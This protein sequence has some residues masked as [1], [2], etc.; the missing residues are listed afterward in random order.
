MMVRS[1]LLL[2]AACATVALAAPGARAVTDAVVERLDP[3]TLI[4]RWRDADPVDVYLAA[5]PTQTVKDARLVV[6]A[7]RDGEERLTV[8]ADS[9]PYVLLRDGG[10]SKVVRVAERLLPLEHGSNFRDVGGYPAAGGK[11]VRWGMI[12]R[13]GG[14]PLLTPED[15]AQVSELGLTRMVDLRS[16]EERSLAPTRIEG[17]PYNAVGYSMAAIMGDGMKPGTFDIKAAYGNFPTLLKPQLRAV[18]IGMLTEKGP[19]AYNCSA[20]QDRTGFVTAMVLSALDVPRDVILADYQLST[21]YRRPEYEMPRIDP[22][23]HAGDPVALFFAKYQS[24]PEAAKPRPL[25]S[26]D[27]TPLIAYSFQAIEAKWGSVDGYLRDAVGLTE[28]DI[29][30]LRKTYLE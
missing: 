4:V 8:E 2:F 22:A 17:V 25:Y 30:A 26:A 20:G 29:K 3:T 24:D 7:D 18:F 28:A 23:A 5:S 15:V 9:R 6:R 10:D 13:S 12:Y 16:S 27:G 21:T 14:T 11:H 1:Q 19:I